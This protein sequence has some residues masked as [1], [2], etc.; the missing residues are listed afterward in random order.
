MNL[1]RLFLAVLL[2]GVFSSIFAQ[3]VSGDYR[4]KAS[5]DW[6]TSG[7]WETYSGSSWSNASVKPASTNS[8]YIQSGHLVTL[9]GNEACYD[10]HIAKGN[11]ST[12]ATNGRCQLDV[13]SLNLYGKLRTYYA[14]VN[15]IPGTSTT[16]MANMLITCT[17]SN[18]KLVV[19]GSSNRT[20]VSSTEW[21]DGTFTTAPTGQRNFNMVIDVDSGVVIT[22]DATIRAY[23]WDI[24]SGTLSV[25]T[26]A[27]IHADTN[28][29]NQGNVTVGTTAVLIANATSS[30][31]SFVRRS[32]GKRGGVFTLDG[33]LKVMGTDTAIA[34]STVNLNGTVEYARN[35]AQNFIKN[36][37]DG[38]VVP[39]P[40]YNVILSG[41]GTKTLA[42]NVT[43]NGTLT[44]AGTASLAA[45]TFTLTYGSTSTLKYRGSSTQTTANTEWPATG[46]PN[47]VIVD[48]SNGVTL[49]SSK[50]T[51]GDLTLLNGTLAM[52]SYAVNIQG[53]TYV[54]DGSYTGGTGYTDGYDDI[55]NNN[56]YINANDVNIT[57]FSGTNSLVSNWPDKIDREWDISGTF[58]GTKTITFYWTAADDLDYDWVTAGVTP[59]AYLGGN[60]ITQIAYDV[61]SD[62][63]YLTID[64]SA[65][66]A[67]GNFKIGPSND[68]SLPI[69]LSSFTATFAVQGGI[70][71]MWITQSETNVRGFYIHRSETQDVTQAVLITNMIAATNTSNMQAYAY[72][73]TD[74]D[75]DGVYYYWL[76]SVELDGND[77]FYGPITFAY[78][79]NGNGNPDTPIIP[80]IN[81]VYPNPFN[82]S[83]TINFGVDSSALATIDIYNSRGQIVRKL[84]SEVLPRGTYH[85]QW[86]GRNNNGSSCPSGMYLM[87]LSI[88]NNSYSSKLMLMK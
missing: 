43:T 40:C 31:I 16:T 41:S 63:R 4:S 28:S 10:L 54:Y 6:S 35:G 76:Q 5:G 29:A 65:F 53:T 12:N 22:M 77:S 62:P 75:H 81:S 15:T 61:A 42:T 13:Y 87:K 49:N 86:D 21:A 48:N 55:T 66:E 2:L 68:E 80:G 82:P 64:V 18:G 19:K 8:V 38:A 52:G 33:I 70:Q 45:S 46:G 72:N 32:S 17:S 24:V 59:S 34:M 79:M 44:M 88:G 74:I 27:I 14:A 25:S 1:R 84:I 71:L 9:T 60:E 58:S 30:T 26:S 3:P 69:E 23:S 7:T 78:T 39:S 11:S 85:R 20:L 73:D 51:A 57:G 67:K 83:T 36:G 47:N 56:F 50:T 37:G